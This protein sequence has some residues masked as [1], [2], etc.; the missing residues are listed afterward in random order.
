MFNIIN[1]ERLMSKI[2]QAPETVWLD[3]TDPDPHAHFTTD[4][5]HCYHTWYCSRHGLMSRWPLMMD[6]H[7]NSAI[8]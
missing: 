5:H 2:L 4:L 1:D 3:L 6:F 8:L 7:S